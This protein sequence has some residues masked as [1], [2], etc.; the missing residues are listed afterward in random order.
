MKKMIFLNVG[1]MRRYQ[2]LA[3]DTIVGGGSYVQEHGY[4]HEIYNFRPYEGYM[5]GYVQVKGTI[6]IERLGASKEDDSAGDILA[7]WVAREPQGGTFIVGWYNNATVYRKW[8]PSPQ[9]SKREY[10]GEELGYH[11][12]ARVEDCK[13]LPIDRRV[14]K[15]PR[16]AKGGMGQSNVW[17][18]DQSINAPFRQ[19][20][21]S[22]VNT[23]GVP[24]GKEPYS[25]RGRS[26]QPD[27]YK[28]KR[29]E[30]KAVELIVA[31]YEE[32]GYTVDSVE[33]DSMGWDLEAKQNDRLLRLET[34]GLSQRQLLIELT[35]NEYDKMRK[36]R[37]SYRVCVVTNALSEEPLLRIFAFSPEIQEWEDDEGN[38]LTI[39]E[40]VSARISSV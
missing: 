39:T 18:A 8:Q 17:Y 29:V 25:K 31:Y 32:L 6:D 37:D 3:G 36:Y 30:Q 19:Q 34:K 21:W 20:V 7:V 14:F 12:K 10:R 13:L 11:V 26:W 27:P 23:D 38:R 2:G 9:G 1:W 4:G 24:I 16:R 22:F 5:Y 28:R 33:R 35:P 40:I 15:V